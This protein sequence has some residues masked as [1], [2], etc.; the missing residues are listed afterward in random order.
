M[1][2]LIEGG[3]EAGWHEADLDATGLASGTYVARFSTDG[4]FNRTQ[5]LTVLR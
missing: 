4:G 2:V 5:R 1:I 3:L